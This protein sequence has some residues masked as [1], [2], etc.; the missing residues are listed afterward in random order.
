GHPPKCCLAW[1]YE[2]IESAM[3][4]YRGRHLSGGLD[5]HAD[6]VF[7]EGAGSLGL[8]H[9]NSLQNATINERNSEKG[10]IVVFACFSEI[11]E[12]G[13]LFGVLFGHG[14]YML[15]HQAG[16]AL[17]NGHTKIANALRTKANG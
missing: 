6:F 9:Q 7:V 10:L 3:L 8:N 11:L 4:A 13:M 14:P 2:A 16:E 17:M 12:A 1:R 5:K 15:G